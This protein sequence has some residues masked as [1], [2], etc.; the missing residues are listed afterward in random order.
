MDGCC[1]LTLLLNFE[2]VVLIPKHQHRMCHKCNAKVQKN[3]GVHM[4]HP[5]YNSDYIIKTN[6]IL[7]SNKP[8]CA[9]EVLG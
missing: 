9:P 6:L 1:L 2:N 4:N 7:M 5:F 8:G 3:E